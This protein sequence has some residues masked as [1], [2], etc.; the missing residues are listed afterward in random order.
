MPETKEEFFIQPMKLSL[1]LPILF[2]FA[3]VHCS[4][5]RLASTDKRRPSRTL[6]AELLARYDL[7]DLRQYAP[8]IQIDLRYAT[9]NN[10]LKQQLYP[11][12]M[13]CLLKRATAEKLAAAQA[14]LLQQGI[15]LCVWDAWRPAEIQSTLVQRLGHSRLFLDPKEAW[16]QHCQGTAVDVALVTAVGGQRLALP[17]DHDEPDLAAAHYQYSG[18]N[19]AVSANLTVLQR[20]MEDAGFR[21]LDTEWWHFNDAKAQPQ[22]PIKA[23][24]L[25][26]TLPEVQ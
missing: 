14:E 11:V 3:L 23:A 21:L 7:V 26:I 12:D 20:I 16:S 17:S 5:E 2:L 6:S 10:L 15:A 24:D 9:R 22:P 13:P 19:P 4:T 8:T 25:G 1:L 18:T